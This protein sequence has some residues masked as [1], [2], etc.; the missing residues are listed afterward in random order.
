MPWQAHQVSPT[1]VETAP[2]DVIPGTGLRESAHFVRVSCNEKISGV[3][4]KPDLLR[5]SSGSR[6]AFILS[7]CFIG[8]DKEEQKCQASR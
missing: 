5:L 2:K 8:F 3:E 7:P 6:V 4:N 1:I